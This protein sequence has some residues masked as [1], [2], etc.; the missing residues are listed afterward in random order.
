MTKFVV[1]T[2]DVIGNA[3]KEAIKNNDREKKIKSIKK[4]ISSLSSAF[5]WSSTEEGYAYWCKVCNNLRSI[6]SECKAPSDED[7]TYVRLVPRPAGGVTLM[8]VD[9]DGEELPC[10]C[11]VS[12]T[13]D[14]ELMRHPGVGSRGNN[15]GL[16][17][18]SG[19][20]INIL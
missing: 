13:N 16:S 6:L 11:L 15:F 12:I 20:Q 3:Y 19:G 10:G 2:E 4:A 8:A 9:K 1:W 14:G 7:T 17:L 18:D 5:Y